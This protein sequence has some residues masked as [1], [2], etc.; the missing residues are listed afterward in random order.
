MCGDYILFYHLCFSDGFFKKIY[1]QMI[2]GK[3]TENK[4]EHKAGINRAEIITKVK[5][6][7]TDFRSL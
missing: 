6:Y 3:N 4:N 2:D 1:G 7:R 5:L